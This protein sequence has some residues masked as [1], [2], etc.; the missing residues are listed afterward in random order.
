MGLTQRLVYRYNT[1]AGQGVKIQFSDGVSTS[2]TRLERPHL[3]FSTNQMV[4][5]PIYLINSAQYG[6]GT[7]PH[8]SAHN[9]DACYTLIQP[10][11]QQS[12]GIE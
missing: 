1:P 5:D 6:N 11:N 9:D 4:G 12:Y 2:Y 7:D 3:A 10:I 8:T